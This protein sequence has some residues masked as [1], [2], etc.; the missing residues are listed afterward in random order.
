MRKLLTLTEVA[1]LLDT[2][3]ARAAELVRLK[4][5]VATYLGRQVRVHPD[6]L[7]EFCKSGGKRLDGG[8]RRRAD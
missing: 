2:T 6:V 7:E 4:I 3:Y 5:I 8:W 1:E